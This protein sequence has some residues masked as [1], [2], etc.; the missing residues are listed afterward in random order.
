VVLGSGGVNSEPPNPADQVK[1]PAGNYVRRSI[2]RGC[3]PA[4]AAPF[5]FTPHR[6]AWVDPDTGPVTTL[7]VVPCAQALG[8]EDGYAPLALNGLHELQAHNDPARPMLVVLAHDGDNAWGGGYDYYMNAVPNLAA[9]AEASGY[10]VTV[11]EQ[12]LADRPVPAGDIVHV[13]DGA[14]VNADGDFGSPRFLNWNWP[15]VDASGQADVAAGWALD[16]RNGAV[17]IAAQNV[18]DTAE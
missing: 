12:Y 5:A 18:V 8:W 2:S 1:P 17:I 6:A 4:E 9:Q 14:W 7:V 10:R 3:S 15:P 11:V 16:E 13:E